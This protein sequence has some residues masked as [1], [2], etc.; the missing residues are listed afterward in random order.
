MKERIMEDKK[1]KWMKEGK[2]KEKEL[3]RK[4]KKIGKHWKASRER[5]KLY[6]DKMCRERKKERKKEIR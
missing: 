2:N 5:E 1:N 3:Q 4:K 6:S